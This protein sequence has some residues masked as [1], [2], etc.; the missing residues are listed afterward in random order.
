[1]EKDFFR[2]KNCRICRNSNLIKILDL[3]KTPLANA[4]L[5]KKDLDKP[6]KKFPLDVYFC[7]NCGLLQLLDIVNPKILFRHY[8]YLSSTSKPLAEHFIELGKNLI[9]RFIK[10]KNDLVIDI[11]GNDAVLLE[12]I[13]KRCR[14]LNIEPASNIAK[15]SKGKGIDTIEEFFGAKL[16]KII[17]E[18]YGSARV[19]T[20]SN[21]I[22]QV[23]N[24]DDIFKGVK[25]LLGDQGV[26]IVE[27]HWVA[28]L[29]GLTGVGGFDQIYHEHLSYFS[30]L[31]F[32]KLVS[33][34][35]LKI[36]DAKLIPVHGQSLQIYISKDTAN[37]SKSVSAVFKKEKSLGLGKKETYLNFAQKVKKNKKGLR[38]LLLKLKRENKKIVG[39]GAP[40]KGNILLNYFRIGNEILDYIV[41][42]SPL[43]QGLYTPSAHIPIYS[44]D[45]LKKDR[46]DYL[47]LLAWNY[48][49]FIL[50]KERD[51]R[52]KGVKF[53]IPIPKI[54]II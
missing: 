41:D 50:N 44:P 52:K 35:G 13:K 15:I 23:D 48:A 45:K 2:K 31:A 3:G 16:A 12:S 10:S 30:L 34:F 20:A 11:G 4:F 14:V 53:I 19:I 42:A 1:M 5:R 29:M 27:V 54:K 51:L 22:A 33:Q 8:Y 9:N 26:F 43:K 49:D 36:F 7:K 25:I 17:F 28:N 47:L 39:Y 38:S 6:E 32:E 40:A 37:I 21:V 24:L 46:P 18:K